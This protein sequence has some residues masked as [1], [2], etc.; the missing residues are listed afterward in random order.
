L[1]F[2]QVR[3]DAVVGHVVGSIS[4]SERPANVVRNSVEESFEDLR[5]TYT[6]NPL[7]KDLIEAAFDI[8]RHSGNL[9][10]ARLLDREVQS[11]FR[12]EI[13]ALDTTASNNP[14]S[15]AITVK[16]EVADVNDNAPEWPQDPIDLQVIKQKTY[17]SLVWVPLKLGI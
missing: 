2:A 7:T 14:Q 11:E 8:D 6:L 10:V 5:V 1:V 9:V 16:I 4:P 17:T 13:R 3:E 15:S 12:L